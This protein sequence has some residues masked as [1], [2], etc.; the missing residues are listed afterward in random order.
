ME[1]EKIESIIEKY[2]LNGLCESTRWDI[3]N[4]NLF[5]RFVSPNKDMAGEIT[6]KNFDIEDSNIAIFNT[7]QLLKLISTLDKNITIN[8][9]KTNKSYTK[10]YISDKIFN[11]TYPLAEPMMVPAVPEINEPSEYDIIVSLDKNHINNIIKAKN[12]LSNDNT[13]LVS[14]DKDLKGNQIIKFTFGGDNDYSNKITYDVI[15]EH[16][17]EKF[18]LD[19][20]IPFDSDILKTILNS[21]KSFDNMIMSINNQGLLKLE[22]FFEDINVKYF[23]LRKADS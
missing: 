6:C 4:R 13:V 17:Y 15:T 9:Q 3:K 5:I 11:I 14:D 16:E 2:H 23:L 19:E 12:S 8:L 10:L 22:F 7:T 21:N 20:P 1:T 18:A